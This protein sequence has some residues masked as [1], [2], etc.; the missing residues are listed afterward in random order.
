[1]AKTY[2][3]ENIVNNPAISFSETQPEGFTLITDSATL[4]S[5]TEKEY[6]KREKDGKDFYNNFRSRL[7]LE[8]L[9]GSITTTEAFTVE[10]Y[11]VDVARNINTG[12]WLTA[13]YTCTNLAISGIFT[14]ELKDEILLGI[15]NYIID[16]Y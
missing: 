4:L 13:Q 8:I 7:Y 6:N 16:N 10:N 9:A 15:S 3:I 11:L 14:Q 2:Y 1:M 5:L 12:N